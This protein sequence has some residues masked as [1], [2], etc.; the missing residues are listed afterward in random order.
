M[1]ELDE[2]GDKEVFI[3]MLCL[4]NQGNPRGTFE[5]LNMEHLAYLLREPKEIVERAFKK[6]LKYKK[7]E[8]IREDEEGLQV[9]V[10]KFK[11]Y[12]PEPKRKRKKTR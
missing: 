2:P 8:I 9:K 11:M 1:M 3:G 4:A 7:I 6:C 10:T 12:N 5:I